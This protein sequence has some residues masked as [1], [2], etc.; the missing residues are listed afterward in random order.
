VGGSWTLVR[1]KRQL[2][3]LKRR[4]GWPQERFLSVRTRSEGHWIK[5][6]AGRAAS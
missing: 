6:F 4:A 1:R 5:M 2:L 3:R